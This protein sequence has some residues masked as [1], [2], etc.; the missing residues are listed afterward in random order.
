MPLHAVPAFV[1]CASRTKADDG[2]AG[3]MTLLN[4]GLCR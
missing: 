3:R 1:F 2:H 4:I